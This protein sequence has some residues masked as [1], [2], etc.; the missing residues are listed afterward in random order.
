MKVSGHKTRSMLDRYNIVG[1]EETGAA[2]TKAD[3]YLSTQPAHRPVI[4]FPTAASAGNT[5]RARTKPTS[6]G[7]PTSVDPL[8]F[9]NGLAEAGGNRTH[10]PGG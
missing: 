6:T 7:L 2:F 9:N 5:D 4:P 3:A 10:R 1:E 8:L